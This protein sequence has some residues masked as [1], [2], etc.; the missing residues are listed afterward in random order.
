MHL[1]FW[2]ATALLFPVLLYQ[3]K[4]ARKTT[5]RLPEAHGSS[6]GHYGDGQPD[7]RLLVIGEST[8][9]SVGVTTHD[10]GLASQLA[11]QLNRVY[12]Q[13]AREAPDDFQYRS[14]SAITDISLLASDG[15]HPNERGYKAIAD[16]L[17]L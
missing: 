7:L 13:L 9:A 4:R 12:E 14:Y 5:P 2:L 15:Y 8:A 3:G 6:C 11:R 17:T 16:G 1:P 10:Q